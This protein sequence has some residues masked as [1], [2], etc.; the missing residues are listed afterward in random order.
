MATDANLRGVYIPIITPFSGDAGGGK[1]PLALDTYWEVYSGMKSGKGRK[2]RSII[3]A[4][5]L[6]YFMGHCKQL[7][8]KENARIYE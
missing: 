8:W 5:F 7:G 4:A 3:C 2:I 6:E 1:D